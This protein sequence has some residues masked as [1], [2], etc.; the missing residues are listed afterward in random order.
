MNL[1]FRKKRPVVEKP[2]MPLGKPRNRTSNLRYE[3]KI[4][5][6]TSPALSVGEFNGVIV[7]FKY[8]SDGLLWQYNNG[9]RE[10]R[11][12]PIPPTVFRI[13]KRRKKTFW[14]KLNMWMKSK[15]T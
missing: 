1:R 3:G 11:Q 15:L 14:N 6:R 2:L 12:I 10:D 13:V 8:D 4:D 7:E 5:P 9:V